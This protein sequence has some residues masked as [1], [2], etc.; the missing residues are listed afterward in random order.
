MSR[1]YGVLGTEY[2]SLFPNLIFMFALFSKYLYFAG[3][4]K[5]LLLRGDRINKL[6]TELCPK[7]LIA[8]NV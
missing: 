6:I 3:V 2:V 7:S 1:K 5:H 8:D 4:S